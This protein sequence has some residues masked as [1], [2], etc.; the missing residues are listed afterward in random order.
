MIDPE[1]QQVAIEMRLVVLAAKPRCYPKLSRYRS[2]ASVAGIEE[3]DEL[4]Y[5]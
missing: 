3:L 2:K 1:R 4:A 5:I